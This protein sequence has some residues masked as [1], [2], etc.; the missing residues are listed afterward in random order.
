MD[1]FQYA[2]DEAT[3]SL[4]PSTKVGAVVVTPEGKNA[5][6]SCNVFPPNTPD[7]IWFDRELKYQFVIH[8]EQAALI[9][10][11]SGSIGSTMYVSEH[12]CAECAKLMAFAGVKKVV[13]PERPWRDDAAVISTVGKARAIFKATGVEVE[14]V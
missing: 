13:C 1:W 4:D 8:A 14:Y 3:Y 2:C 11:E 12:P 10:A 6:S 7:E 5:G 9:N